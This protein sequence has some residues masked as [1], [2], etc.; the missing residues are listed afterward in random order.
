MSERT[1]LTINLER[2]EGIPLVADNRGNSITPRSN[3]FDPAITCGGETRRINPQRLNE[4]IGQIVPQLGAIPGGPSQPTPS[5]PYR[6]HPDGLREASITEPA[7]ISPHSL[8]EARTAIQHLNGIVSTV[9]SGTVTLRDGV[10]SPL[11]TLCNHGQT[12]GLLQ[13]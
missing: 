10:P 13:R 3:P 8:A 9:A 5:Q 1:T 4:I 6:P 2:S 7:G 11:T 12:S